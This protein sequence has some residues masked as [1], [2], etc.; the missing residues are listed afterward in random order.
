[1]S[2]CPGTAA[3]MGNGTPAVTAAIPKPCRRPFGQACGPEIPAAAMTVATFRCAV[4]LDIGQSESFTRHG[5]ASQSRC[6]ISRSHASSAAW[7]TAGSLCFSVDRGQ[8]LIGDDRDLGAGLGIVAVKHGLSGRHGARVGLPP[9]DRGLKVGTG[10]SAAASRTS[11][12]SSVPSIRRVIT[13][14]APRQPSVPPDGRRS[15]RSRP[16]YRRATAAGQS[17]GTA[18]T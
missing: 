13:N 9:G 17:E 6:T 3:I 11:L 5:E 10:Y 16:I 7:R 14:A 8:Q 4:A 18:G 1:M 15:D 12:P 2:A